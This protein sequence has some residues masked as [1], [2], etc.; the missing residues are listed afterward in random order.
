MANKE[1]GQTDQI[2]M[3]KELMEIKM[4]E[5]IEINNKQFEKIDQNSAKISRLE[6]NGT[7]GV[8]FHMSLFAY[9]SQYLKRFDIHTV[10]I[11]VC[12]YVCM[13]VHAN[14]SRNM[15]NCQKKIKFRGG[16]LGFL[17]GIS[18]SI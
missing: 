13:Y 16:H 4:K 17:T 18:Q 8:I 5:L 3:I 15:L 11:S 10:C 12:M 9:V 14:I 2:E 6:A 7:S 1:L